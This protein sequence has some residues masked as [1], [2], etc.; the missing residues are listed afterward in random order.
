M[1]IYQ[2]D[3]GY[4]QINDI[5]LDIPPEQ[6]SIHRNSFNHQWQTLRTRSSVK[7]KSG[8]SQL[9]IQVSVKFTD[10]KI[11]G[12]S[13]NGLQK[14]RDLVSQFRVTPFCYVENQLLRNTILNGA[15]RPNMAL[16]LKQLQLYVDNTDG[17]NVVNVQMV[18]AWFNYFPYLPDF[19]FKED[20]FLPSEVTNPK[21]SKA[22]KLMYE[23][24][25]RR[26]QYK[27]VRK[28][29]QV[30]QVPGNDGSVH[31]RLSFTQFA[32]M[33][34]TRYEETKKEVNALRQLEEV[35][36]TAVAEGTNAYSAPWLITDTL[37]RSLQ[38]NQQAKTLKSEVLG[39]VT[40][41]GSDDS[42]KWEEIEPAKA[43]E[44]V[45]ACL[46]ADA[47]TRFSLFSDDWTTVRLGSESGKPQ[48]V[49]FKSEP[50]APS[51]L[52]EVSGDDTILLKRGR[53]LILEREGLILTSISISFEN[54]L[55]MMPMMG[56]AYP[57]YQHIGSVDAAVTLSMMATSQKALQSLSVF[58]AAIE[59]QSLKYK[60]IPGGQRNLIVNND[61]IEMCGLKEFIPTNLTI[62]TVPDAP[63]TYTA[64][65]SIV[66]NPV[67]TETKE[68]ISPGQSFTNRHDI[69]QK[70]AKVIV[71]SLKLVPN[72]VKFSQNVLYG[73]KIAPRSLQEREFFF[74]TSNKDPEEAQMEADAYFRKFSEESG[75]IPVA[76]TAMGS[77][78]LGYNQVFRYSGYYIYAGPRGERDS[79]F[80]QICTEYGR[81]LG[82]AF[83]GLAEVFFD[84]YEPYVVGPVTE[85]YAL[86][87]DDVLSVE[88]LQRDI[89]RSMKAINKDAVI[90]QSTGGEIAKYKGSGL[91]ALRQ[92]AKEVINSTIE[93]SKQRAI[94]ARKRRFM[95]GENETT[96]RSLEEGF[97]ESADRVSNFINDYLSVW[98]NKATKFLDDIILTG[99]L[100]LPQFRKILKEVED[101]N[102]MMSSTGNCYPDFP[103][104]QIRKIIEAGS[105]DPD[106][107]SMQYA[108]DVLRDMSSAEETFFKNIGLGALIGPDFY[109][110]N[111]INDN[112][113]DFI[114]GHVLNMAVE[115]IRDS[116]GDKRINS[117][118]AWFNTVYE[119]NIIGKTEA[120]AI[121]TELSNL[122]KLEDGPAKELL[123]NEI[124]ES[125]TFA[126]N[127]IQGEVKCSI[128]QH[129]DHHE[130]IQVNAIDEN[131]RR[132][133]TTG[134]VPIAQ[135]RK[136]EV[137]Q[138]NREHFAQ[139]NHL[140]GTN[141]IDYQPA[142]SYTPSEPEDPGKTPDFIWPVGEAFKPR[143]HGGVHTT[144]T[145]KYGYRGNPFK[146]KGDKRKPWVFHRGI[147]IAGIGK[148]NLTANRQFTQTI[149]VH[150][151]ASGK[152]VKCAD[153]RDTKKTQRKGM[154]IWIEHPGGWT[155]TYQHMR[156]DVKETIEL[157]DIFHGRK[158]GTLEVTK[159]QK[160]GQ[161]GNTGPSTGPHLHHGLLF[162]GKFVDPEQVYSGGIVKS[163]GPLPNIDP[164]NESLLTKSVEQFEKDIR[165]G[166]GY[167]MMRA[168]PTFRLYFIES[169]LG[170][171]R[172]FGFD[173]F[174]NYNAVK[175]IQVVRSRK[176]PADLCVIDLTN[177]SGVL[178]N[179]KF[180]DGADP[181]G[182]KDENGQTAIERPGGAQEGRRRNT[183]GENP[184]VSLMLQ[185]G[186]QIQLRLGYKS[187]PEEL[188]KV[189]NGVI[190]D[191]QF[192][193]SDDLVRIVCQSFAVELVQNYH[194]KVKSFDGFFSSAGRTANILEQ[195]MASPEVVHF[196]RWEGGPA[197]NSAYWMLHSRW[198][199]QPQPADD[200]IFAPTG[201]GLLGLFDSTSEY[202]LYQTTIWDVF[203]EMTLRH[204]GYIAYAVPY[205]GKFGPRMT[206]FFG[207]PD[208]MYFARDPS[209]MEDST[210]NL[211]QKNITDA[212]NKL[213][214]DRGQ[215]DELIDPN[216]PVEMLDI[217]PDKLA[218]SDNDPWEGVR[219]EWIER[220][221]K[222]IAKD[223]GIIKPFRSYHLLN[224]T[225]HIIFN[226][227]QSSAASCF[228]TV[229]LQYG[230]SSPKVDKESG[231]LEFG[232]IVGGFE[233]FTLR[234]DAGLPDEEVREMFA[235]YPSCVGYEMA[236]RYC[237][238]LL[239]WTLKDGY[240]GKVITIG[241]PRI[242]PYDI[243]YIFDE[244]NDMFGPV[245]VEQV[246]HKFSQRN[247][248][249]TEV[250]PD[251]VIHV[252]QSSTMSTSDAMGLIVENAITGG[253]V[254]SLPT[255]YTALKGVGKFL[256]FADTIGFGPI[257]N[258]VF[259]GPSNAMDQE[260]SSGAFGMVG[261]FIFRKL[262][263]RTQLAQPFRY[264]PLTKN[265]K[266]MIGGTPGRKVDGSFVQGI[267]KWAK[268]ADEGISLMLEDF[269]YKI[270]P[271]NWL[272]QTQGSAM[273]SLFGEA[274]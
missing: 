112:L 47:G 31:T 107:T 67:T 6:I 16:A 72:A 60:N 118:G 122:T 123:Q 142:S 258:M 57:S 143:Q 174:F 254:K 36:R 136:D 259:N 256:S 196:G 133:A 81:I 185:A 121:R 141:S 90:R 251:M 82:E 189:F 147:D 54:I 179:R 2:E 163:Q 229:T 132:S 244:Y 195:L 14:L 116:Q 187:N 269:Y 58:Y 273:Q 197:K 17:T 61:L 204:P 255:M 170:E 149:A 96:L 192:N 28:L 257:A 161:I 42:G 25:Q 114:P 65:L 140:F 101:S 73:K 12:E 129:A 225:Q 263:T 23:A 26:T 38:N 108:F 95:G 214:E 198:R 167:S 37:T 120:E 234:C 18:F 13:H 110:Y 111:K 80:Q 242:K 226:N 39:H 66:D 264:S 193:E 63:E 85:F 69:R 71:Q 231:G 248:F 34:L 201:P 43:L 87:E 177:V 219:K 46:A 183:A 84:A 239:F 127:D 186:I 207:V 162:N 235:Q 156:M 262:I 169:D 158:S 19:T 77:R 203:Q 199:F 152:I 210:G 106:N 153:V 246:V 233:T 98:E 48:T 131:L 171:R 213:K 253:N 104:E 221:L 245:E 88:I 236:K 266:P 24:E 53:E 227:I 56:H 228:N 109:F 51:D 200:N 10:T 241:N 35:L 164:V 1:G 249:I 92:N 103:I 139:C 154:K 274:T 168:Y 105:K 217:Q 94:D 86:E 119:S 64:T 125:G 270:R 135:E 15:A 182:N 9:D 4:F 74:Q 173:D 99:R 78:Q 45:T 194:G 144:I 8:Y 160:I 75:K 20:I 212:V 238:A 230:D 216:T 44:A 55:A 205:E 240:K 50:T 206:M 52:E 30:P 93:Q 222:N 145:S 159:G 272:N 62:A 150:A 220:S 3:T 175:E 126:P 211:L 100:R 59:D 224:T 21:Q 267:R 91:S 165:G 265:G 49:K 89:A 209:F 260:T 124:N 138:P 146:Q 22:W 223:R 68:K 188:E 155:S 11:Q 202:I 237:V 208:Q 218:K 247:G 252:N 5:D 137:L 190:T 243:C 191:V 128:L 79:V 157:S 102:M 130:Q 33:R 27:N 7:S 41:M 32:N 180:I 184:I 29:L 181:L 250:T 215:L 117:E 113:Q 176:I 134:R 151:V 148:G 268:E 83:A 261:A 178:S 115:S 97:L 166:Q 76:G 232:G 271:N 172:R 40:S 70:V